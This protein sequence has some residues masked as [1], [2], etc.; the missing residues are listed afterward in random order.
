M[1]TDL[2]RQR[3]VYLAEVG[4]GN[5]PLLLSV[6]AMGGLD[7][8]LH[9]KARQVFVQALSLEVPMLVTRTKH[10]AIS[11]ALEAGQD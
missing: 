5:A 1:H 9:V 7:M 4:A 11:V 2:R 3:Q 8:V 10:P 6:P